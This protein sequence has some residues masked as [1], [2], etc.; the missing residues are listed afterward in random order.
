MCLSPLLSIIIPVYNVENYLAQCLDS[1]LNQSYSNIEIV[2]VND[3]STDK[4]ADICESYAKKDSRIKL[5]HKENGGL[6]SARNTGLESISGEYVA[7]LD[8]DDW[9]EPDA[10]SV[11]MAPFLKFGDLDVSR[12]EYREVYLD[13][14]I[15]NKALFTQEVILNDNEALD[16]LCYQDEFLA[17]VWSSVYKVSSLRSLNLIF[18]NG[19]YHEDEFFTTVLYGCSPNFRLYYSPTI[20]L[21]YRKDREGAI[22]KTQTLRNLHDLLL[23]YQSVYEAYERYAPEKISQI[24]T[25]IAKQVEYLTLSILVGHYNWD[26]LLDALKSWRQKSYSYPLEK[27]KDT[28]L[29]E[30][31][32]F[33]P[34]LSYYWG[35]V[36]QPIARRLGISSRYR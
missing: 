9:L 8:S 24:H 21:N 27:H 31:F 14:E 36:Y 18:Q 32:L 15:D 22:T 7:F 16:A 28:W 34:K 26:E 10:Y 17:V 1:V 12:A 25:Y 23:G 3:G 33:N 29:V 30:L 5:I 6:S 19:L 2:L 13:R 4:S 11:L 35:R 20:V